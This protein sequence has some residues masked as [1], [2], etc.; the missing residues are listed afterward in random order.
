MQ[1]TPSLP[2][3]RKRFP[4]T[5]LFVM[6]PVV[7]MLTG[8]GV[9]SSLGRVPADQIAA[10]VYV[11]GLDIGGKSLE[12]AKAALNAWAEKRSSTPMTL[13][14]DPATGIAR[15]WKPEAKK[16]GLGINVASTLDAAGKYGHEGVLGQVSHWMGRDN[17]TQLPAQPTVDTA[18]LKA[19]LRQLGHFVNRPPKNARLVFLPGGGFG[20]RH[21]SPGVALDMEGSSV[22]IINAWKSFNGAPGAAL[23]PVSPGDGQIQAPH[24]VD[25]GDSGSATPQSTDAA[26]TPSTP[27]PIN[28]EATL[29]ARA[30]PEAVTSET[31][32]QV[33]GVL[34]SYTTRFSGTGANRGS[35]VALAASHIN[36]TLIKP[37][38]IFSYNKIVGPRDED[39]GFKEAPVIVK[40]ELEPGMGGGVCQVSSTLYNAVLRSDLKIVQRSHHAFPVHY[41]PAGLDATV[42]YGAIDFQFQNNTAAPIYIASG[43][44]HG[45]LSFTIFGKRTPGKEVAIA[46][47]NHTVEPAPVVTAKDPSLPAGRQVVKSAGHRGHRVTVYRI[48]RENGA[49]VRKEMISHDHY[50]TFPVLVMVGSRAKPVRKPVLPAPVPNSGVGGVNPGASHPALPAASGGQ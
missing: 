40:G 19:Y 35:N 24:G 48:V 43:S 23:E 29:K 25:P 18:R 46:L 7:V 1:V 3:K 31:L 10:G 4:T 47:A 11:A 33:D 45:R 9:V 13:R 44:R 20:Q 41:L 42:V 14:F 17:V 36:G 5:T 38:G 30:V 6:A 39:S 2:G 21:G 50:R 26:T 27:T 34:G 32:K 37:G 22:A 8:A 28:P 16:L 15:V 49:V 12:E